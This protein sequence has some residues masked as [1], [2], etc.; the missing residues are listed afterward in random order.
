LRDGLIEGHLIGG[1]MGGLV[2]GL[3]QNAL[4]ARTTVP[5]W[6]IARRTYEALHIV[7]DAYNAGDR[8]GYNSTLRLLRVHEFNAEQARYILDLLL[9]AGAVKEY[10]DDDEEIP[11]IMIDPESEAFQKIS[12]GI[13]KNTLTYLTVGAGPTADEDEG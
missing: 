12:E 6:I 8:H 10:E 3:I 1:L 4:H 7:A 9:R 2:G 13:S 5:R 11:F